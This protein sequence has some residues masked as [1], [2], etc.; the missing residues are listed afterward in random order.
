MKAYLIL[1]GT[2]LLNGAMLDTNSIYMADELNKLSIE[3]VGKMSCMDKV[4]DI[5]EAIGFARKRSEL[6][7]LSGGPGHDGG[8]GGAEARTNQ[9]GQSAEGEGPDTLRKVFIRAG[10]GGEYK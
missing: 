8:A 4:E 5:V 7:I 3:V 9:Q 6:I 1:V 10:S 2:E